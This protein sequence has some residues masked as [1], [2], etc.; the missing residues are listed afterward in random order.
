[1]QR[2]TIYFCEMLYMFQ[3]VPPHIIRSSKIY[4]I[5]YFVKLL[6]SACFIVPDCGICYVQ[7]SFDVS[8]LIC[9][10]CLFG[11]NG[12]DVHGSMLRKY[13]SNPVQ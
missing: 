8:V 3:A 7:I 11:I 4:S 9:F 6:F 5:G 12:F 1:M 2:Y 13:I 10:F